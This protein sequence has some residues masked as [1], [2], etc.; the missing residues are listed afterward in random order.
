MKVAV[1]CP[2]AFTAWNF[3]RN[4]LKALH[5]RQYEVA[6]IS[7]PVHEADVRHLEALGVR[8]IPLAFARFVSPRSDLGFLVRLYR[9]LRAN[10]F[11][12]VHSFNLKCH[13]YGTLVAWLARV[14][15]I[16]GT[17]EGLGF[18]YTER[19]GAR[20]RLLEGMVDLLNALACRLA[21]RVWFVNPDDLEFLAARKVAVRNKA[22]VARGA[23][24]DVDEFSAAAAD[25][26]KLE[27]VRSELAL[28]EDEACVTM[29]VARA[30]WSKGVREFVEAADQLRGAYP[31][32]RFVLL[33]PV[34]EAS[35]DA[36]PP[37]Y[38]RAAEQRNPRF[39]WLSTFRRDVR[40]I[41]LL[42]SIVALPSYYREGL[43][44][45][46]MEAMAMGKP[47]VTT[48]N[49]GCREVVEEGRNGF[50]VNVKD[51]GALAQA[52]GRLLADAN[53]RAGFGR[54][55]RDKAVTEFADSIVVKRVLSEM[56][57]VA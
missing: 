34:E 45:V 52:L 11:D 20:R 21:D 15:N 56:Y 41:L 10:R 37:A 43:P 30:V 55:S 4:L 23:G 5:E 2:D 47:I 27:Q 35:P 16:F 12:Y 50:L 38:L 6:V 46:L 54:R 40:E 19:P 7:A 39:V 57:G 22:M 51:T 14:P 36:V 25:P 8:H 13:I 42:S 9:I 1:I 33:A 31:R 18:T 48:D 17:I 3:H 44:N 32:T 24:I 29:P 49:V 28:A 53:L 26:I